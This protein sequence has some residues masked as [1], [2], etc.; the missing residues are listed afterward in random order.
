VSNH[1]YFAHNLFVYSKH[2]KVGVKWA[3]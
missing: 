2:V 3:A 1:A